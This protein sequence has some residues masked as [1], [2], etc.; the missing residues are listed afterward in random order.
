MSLDWSK[1]PNFRKSEFDCKHTGINRMRPEFMER[2]QQI[3]D[4]FDKPLIITSGYR[5]KT[6]PVEAS[7]HGPGEHYYGCAA[8][9]AISGTDAMDLIVIAYGHGIRRIGLKQTGAGRFIHLGMGDQ[10]GLGFPSTIWTY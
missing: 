8:D 10:L 7:K 9:V 5:D 4:T 3:R 2:L 1:Y 6:H